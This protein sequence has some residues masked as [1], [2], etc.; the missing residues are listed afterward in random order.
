MC[1]G[2]MLKQQARDEKEGKMRWSGKN[3][4]GENGQTSVSTLYIGMLLGSALMSWTIMGEIMMR[5][6]K[7]SMRMCWSFTLRRRGIAQ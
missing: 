1:R 5:L 2:G 6:R 3:G 4:G 7:S